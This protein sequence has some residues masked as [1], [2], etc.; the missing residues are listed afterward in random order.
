MAHLC[1]QREGLQEQMKRMNKFE[2]KLLDHEKE[3]NK[4]NDKK[5]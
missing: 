3:I 5:V 1:I 2:D 4:K